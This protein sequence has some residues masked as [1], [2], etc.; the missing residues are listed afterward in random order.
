MMLT[1]YHNHTNW[2][3]GTP[4]IAEQ[5]RAAV[6]AGLDEVGISDHY[7]LT[8]NPELVTWSMPIDKLG[9]YVEELQR[10]ARKVPGIKV[11]VG[12]EADYFPETVDEL[13]QTLAQFPFDYVIGSVHFV[14]GFPLDST[15]D[16]WEP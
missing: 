9:K 12:V 10:E 13:R 7:V 15:A 16:D 6:D 11:R 2:S 4:T 3:D 5:L 14:D 8:P 1:S